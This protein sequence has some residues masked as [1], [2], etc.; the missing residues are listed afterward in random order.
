MGSILPDFD[1]IIGLKKNQNHRQLWTHY[2]LFW[3]IM[4]FF[5]FLLYQPITW[6]FLAGFIHVII[7]VIDW[8]VY[9][10]APFSFKTYSILGLNKEQ[11]L[12]GK[13]FQK[14]VLKYYTNL[15]ILLAEFSIISLCILSFLLER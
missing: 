14:F 4:A 5:A 2:P 10:L 3:L 13:T 8:N 11:Y 15:G 6:L 12:L 1:I 7:D 9:L